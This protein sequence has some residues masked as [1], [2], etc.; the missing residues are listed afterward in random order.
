[1]LDIC[2]EVGRELTFNDRKS[3]NFLY[4]FFFHTVNEIILYF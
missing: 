1:M 4:L 2:G 3:V